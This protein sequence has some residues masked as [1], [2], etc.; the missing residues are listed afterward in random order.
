[1]RGVESQEPRTDSI[2]I[3]S[4]CSWKRQV[5]TQALGAQLVE[6]RPGPQNLFRKKRERERERLL[7]IKSLTLPLILGDIY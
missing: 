5:S 7:Q 3:P 6:L 1:M 4:C 2:Q